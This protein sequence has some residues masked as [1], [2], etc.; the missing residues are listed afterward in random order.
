MTK[1]GHITCVSDC[2]A[3]FQWLDNAWI[4]PLLGAVLAVGW[5]AFWMLRLQALSRR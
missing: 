3:P 1:T 5:L 2:G 4:F